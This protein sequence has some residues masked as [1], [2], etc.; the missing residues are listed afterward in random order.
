MLLENTLGYNLNHLNSTF[1]LSQIILYFSI[2]PNFS[3][4]FL[5][6]TLIS[7]V[8]S[9]R[10]ECIWS[11]FWMCTVPVWRYYSWYSLRRPVYFGFMALTI[12]PPMLNRWLANGPVYFG[13]CA[14][15]TSVRYFCWWYSS[16]HCLAMKRC[17]AKS[18][19]I[20]I[21]VSSLAGLSLCHQSFAYQFMWSINFWLHPERSNRYVLN[22]ISSKTESKIKI[23]NLLISIVK[24][25]SEW[26]PHSSRKEPSQLQFQGKF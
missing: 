8:C 10:V 17:W 9:I 21:G 20:P 22:K 1:S 12:F 5:R 18:I 23:T 2:V 19:R 11:I 26:L 25:R 6:S 14:G 13:A 7:F 24:M 15:C 4:N 16:F 3:I